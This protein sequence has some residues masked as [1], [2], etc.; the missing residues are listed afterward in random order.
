MFGWNGAPRCVLCGVKRS[1]VRTP[2]IAWG[3]HPPLSSCLMSGRERNPE[4]TKM[5]WS[6]HSGRALHVIVRGSSRSCAFTTAHLSST[7]RGIGNDA[8]T[9]AEPGCNNTERESIDPLRT[10]TTCRASAYAP[11][12]PRAALGCSARPWTN[13]PWWRRR[14][15]A[16]H[17]A[18]ATLAWPEPYRSPAVLACHPVTSGAARLGQRPSAFGRLIRDVH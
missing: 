3:T 12:S 17:A 16:S 5:C 2:S 4:H 14:T 6:T 18:P 8:G 7:R 15:T 13:P 1:D 10:T 9:T 11:A